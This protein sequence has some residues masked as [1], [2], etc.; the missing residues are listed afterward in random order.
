VNLAGQTGT[1]QVKPTGLDANAILVSPTELR[2]LEPKPLR[3]FARVKNGE[4]VDVF[5]K[6]KLI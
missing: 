5:V 6:T 2:R 3:Q 4:Q 1:Q